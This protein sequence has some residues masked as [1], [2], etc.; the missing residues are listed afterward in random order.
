MAWAVFRYYEER[1]WLGIKLLSPGSAVERFF[2][3]LYDAVLA[4]PLGPGI[5]HVAQVR[6]RIGSFLMEA[7][8]HQV[9]DF[10]EH[11]YRTYP[12]E[13]QR[14]EFADRVNC[15]MRDEN[16]AY[17]LL[18][19]D[20]IPIISDEEIQEVEEAI[21]ADVEDPVTIHLRTALERLSDRESP[22]YRNSVK[23][24]ISAVEA[25]C[26]AI[27]GERSATL[28]K[29]LGRI[30]AAAGIK[31]HGALREAFKKLYGYTSDSG[32]IRHALTDED[33]LGMEDARFMLVACSA[34]VNYLR[35]KQ[36][37]ANH[38]ESE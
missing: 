7:E 26:V 37:W 34:F 19:G 21:G 16:T 24:S 29:A 12:F 33:N 30:E 18:D 27:S 13:N 23:E 31:I 15:I 6:K 10:L 35:A 20:F 17:R 5:I 8:W 28:G 11:C 36:A 1:P 25:L 22:D 32:G 2:A 9:Y 3:S 14:E 38:S 4:E